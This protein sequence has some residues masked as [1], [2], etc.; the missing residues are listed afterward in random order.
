MTDLMGRRPYHK[1]TIVVSLLIRNEIVVLNR[2][3]APDPPVLGS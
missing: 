2:P 3:K 1:T